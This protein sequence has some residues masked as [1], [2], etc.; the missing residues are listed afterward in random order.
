LGGEV[1][2]CAAGSEDE[3]EGRVGSF[4]LCGAYRVNKKR[5][6]EGVGRS[7]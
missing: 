6:G 1:V 2:V 5:G 7:D 4:I 3:G